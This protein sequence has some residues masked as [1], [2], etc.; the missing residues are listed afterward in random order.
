MVLAIQAGVPLAAVAQA[1]GLTSVEITKTV[2]AP[3]AQEL[4]DKF[5]IRFA[6]VLGATQAIHIDYHGKRLM[7]EVE[8]PYGTL[9]E[10]ES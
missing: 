5:T 1:L 8:P 7:L 4:S 9:S 10:G 3:Y 2:Y 6:A